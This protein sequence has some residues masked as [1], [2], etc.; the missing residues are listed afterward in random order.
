MP[1]YRSVKDQDA[2]DSGNYEADT[3]AHSTTVEQVLHGAA[4]V[5]S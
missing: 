5:H 4:S 3:I 2:L 1:H